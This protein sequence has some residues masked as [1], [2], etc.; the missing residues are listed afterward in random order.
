MGSGRVDQP[1][2]AELMRFVLHAQIGD[3]ATPVIVE[4]YVFRVNVDNL[5]AYFDFDPRRRIDLQKL[6]KLVRESA[7]GLKRYFHRGTPPGEP[8][9]R[10]KMIGYGRFH[11]QTRSGKSRNGQSLVLRFK[12]TT[13]ASTCRSQT[14]MCHWFARMQA[15]W[16]K[17]EAGVTTLAS[18]SMRI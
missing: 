18:R 9:M 7:P 16:V 5:Q 12:R 2:Q 17:S 13:S 4:V 14:M 3:P 6:D 8:G 10:F 15:S 1:N 11:H